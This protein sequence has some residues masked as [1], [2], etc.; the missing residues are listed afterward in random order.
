MHC[1]LEHGQY[2]WLPEG[3]RRRRLEFQEILGDP[4]LSG[5]GLRVIEVAHKGSS[6]S[7]REEA[8]VVSHLVGALLGRQWRNRDDELAPIGVQQIVIVTP[9]NA[10]I[11]AIQSAAA[12]TGLPRLQVGTVEKF[13]GREAPGVIYSMATSSA[14]D[15]PRGMEFL[16]CLHRFNVATSRAHSL[17]IIVASPDLARV[18]CQTPRQ[19]HLAN[20]LS[21][22]MESAVP[23]LAG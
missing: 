17:A 11:R 8:A 16:Y 22:A 6:K 23:T 10:Q 9:Y 19:M 15:A 20:A 5:A 4:P 13:Q 1:C 7:S 3:G 2:F 18:A 21:H 12:E 14:D